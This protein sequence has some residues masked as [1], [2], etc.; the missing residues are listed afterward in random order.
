MTD[1]ARPYRVVDASNVGWHLVGDG[2]Y[3][4][5]VATGLTPA[6]YRTLDD[7]RGPLRPVVPA[8]AADLDVL[9]E[10]LTGAGPL[11]VGSLA[12]A[13]HE[14]AEATRQD[15][16]AGRPGSW[17]A[18]TLRTLTHLGRDLRR[19]RDHGPTAAVVCAILV[20][21]VSDPAGFVEV[22]ETLAGV[23]G[24][25]VDRRGGWGK[26]A[27]IGIRSLAYADQLRNYATS[28]SQRHGPGSGW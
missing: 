15:L 19:D 22:A 8:P 4:P 13:L 2:L 11:A 16:T 23:L 27:E 12:R 7:A 20:R 17:E 5:P 25:V 1:P 26:V 3:H 10:A 21:W 6:T 14:A 18:D 24:R 28:H 9:V